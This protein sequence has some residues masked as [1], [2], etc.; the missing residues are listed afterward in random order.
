MCG[1]AGLWNWPGAAERIDAMSHA[2]EHR[3]PDG[4]AVWTSGGV[5]PRLALAHRRLSIIDLSEAANQPFEKDG[6]IMVFNGEIY[7]Y[8]ELRRELEGTGIRFR[9]HSD[10]EVLLEAFRA[11]D[12]A[13]FTRLRGMFALGVYDTVT[14]RFVLARDHFGIKPL[15][16]HQT[17]DRLAFASELKALRTIMDDVEPNDEALAASLLFN[18]IPDHLCAVKGVEKL[19]AGS[20]A[21]ITPGSVLRVHRYFRPS[22]L[23]DTSAGPIDVD[24][25]YEIVEDSVRA[26]LIADVEVATFLSGGLDSSLVS[27]I[28]ANR[29]NDLHAFTISFR[30][31]DQKIEAMPDDLKYARQVAQQFGITLNEVVL[32]PNVVSMLPD[33]VHSLDEPI[34]DPASINTYLICQGARAMN[35][36]VL[37]SGMGA[38]EIFGGYR[39][40]EAFL[41]ADRF[42]HLP[43]VVQKGIAFGASPLPVV[44]FGHG[45]RSVRWVKKFLQFASL[46]PEESFLR[47]Y[48]YYGE[49]DLEALGGR[50]LVD[51]ASLTRRAHA[52]SFDAAAGLGP[53]NQMCMVDVEWF[54]AGLN[55]TYSDRASMKASTEV[56]VPFVDIKVARAA[57]RCTGDQKL[58]RSG[59]SY[60]SKAI[61]KDAALRILPKEVV[62]RPKAPF[63]APLRAWISRDLRDMITDSLPN[64]R[65]VERGL[66]SQAGVDR[67][68]KEEFSGLQDRSKELWQLLTIETW[69]RDLVS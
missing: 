15:F 68:I 25:L 44:A 10:T 20:W 48:S 2:I 43:G 61:L 60:E 65:L 33:I 8:Q 67:L 7:N 39:K 9:T 58:R 56:R 3:G 53:V 37:L 26:H 22:E 5:G 62:F 69:L 11:W 24:E 27:A 66:V 13:C 36:K 21:E 47:S 4:S 17:G 49:S 30:P 19:P 32:E 41:Q 50:H 31:Q 28:A 64:G 23:A 16:V 18:W 51:L 14:Q 55:L 42:R 29:T 45:L 34:G 12:T 35:R 1:V 59:M 46:P 57:F 54:M 38:D 40:H 6:L 63:A 52:R